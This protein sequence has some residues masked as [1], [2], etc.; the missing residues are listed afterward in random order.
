M[1]SSAT[2]LT[3]TNTTGVFSL[4]AGYEIPTTASIA[5][6]DTAYTN[7]ITSL[8]TTGSSGSAT[9]SSNTLNIPTYTLSGLGGQPLSTNLTSLS[10]ITYASTSFVKMTASGTFTLDTNTYYLASNPSSYIALTGLSSSATGLTY[11]NT[12]GVFSL[13][14]GYAIPTTASATNWDTAYTNRITSLTTTGSSGASTLVSNVL[15]I[16]TYTL[17]GL[18]GVPTTRSLTINGTAYDLSADRTWTISTN[19]SAR[20]E[21]NFVATAAQTTF[22]ITGGYVVGLV[23]VYVNGVRYLPTDY[24]ATNGTT[25]VLGIGLLAGDAVTILNY[26]SSIAALPT[27]RNVQDFTATA[28]QTTFTVTNGYIVGLIDVYVNGSK[29]TSSEFTATNGT[30]FVLTVAST[31]GDQVQSI[32]Y[33][34]SVNGISGAGTA[35]YVPKFTASGTIGNSS[36]F[37][38]GT[39]VGIGTA[40]PGAKLQVVGSFAE[41]IRFGTNTS[42][43]TNISMG[44]GFTVFDSIGGDSGAFDFRDDSTSRLFISTTGNVGIGTTS[45]SALLTISRTTVA[46]GHIK[47]INTSTT[48]DASIQVGRSNQTDEQ[49]WTFGQGVGGIGDSFGFYTGGDSRLTITTSGTVQISNAAGLRLYTEGN[50]AYWMLRTYNAVSNQLR[51]NYQGSDLASIATST[52]NYTALSDVNKKKDFEASQI[53]LNEVLGLKPTLYRMKTEADTEDK[54]LGFIAQEVKEFIPQAYSE[55]GEG[56]DKFIGLSE[57]PIIAALVK[58]VQQQQSQIEELKTLLKA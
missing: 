50:G 49:R 6:W 26:T 28:A 24:T 56:D 46:Y 18:G 7:R 33:T 9:L 12:T 4:T 42:V 34:A 40:S 1:S 52:G 30:T 16:P 47:I 2:G 8:T 27:S 51:F 53:G 22:T 48:G 35:N 14:A 20:A 54:H 11:T 37:D 29:L 23:D 10:G 25:V 5:T 44:T 57:M 41:Q 31:V 39:N 15:N 43:Y 36:I 17:T 32:N 45:P 21:E 13:T 19:P 38:N 58:A 3:Y 55:T